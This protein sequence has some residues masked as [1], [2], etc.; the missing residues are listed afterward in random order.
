MSDAADRSRVLA[1]SEWFT[2][3]K[4]PS[5]SVERLHEFRDWRSDAANAEAFAKVERMWT[6]AANLSDRPAIR[7]ATD[8]ALAAHPARPARSTRTAKSWAALAVGG[9]VVMGGS[10]IFVLR[11]LGRTYA[12]E[13]GEQRLTQ[14]E[15]GSRVRLNTDTKLKVHFDREGRR[16][17]LIRGQAFFDVAHD[18][19]RP[20]VVEA[21]GAQA[22]ALGTRFDVRRH[23][24][25]LRVVVLQGEVAVRKGEAS[26]AIVVRPN[27]A[28]TVSASGVAPPRQID[29]QEEA[30]WTSGR[31]TFRGVPLRAAVEEVNRY[32]EQKIVLQAPGD[33]ADETVSGQF[34]AG[35]TATFLAALEAVLNLRVVRRSDREIRVASPG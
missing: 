6:S 4:R 24:A 30:G 19:K 32:S 12:T 29:A 8:A 13:V 11:D 3:L 14:L 28:V 5:I 31:L 22:H 9:L 23:A 20:F 27:Q 7:A 21:E 10:A 2:E 16:I 17:E 1:A 33:L 26:P 25:A 15:D 34:E 18:P 35:D